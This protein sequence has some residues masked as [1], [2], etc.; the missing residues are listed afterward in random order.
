MSVEGIYWAWSHIAEIERPGWRLVLLHLA[1]RASS[2][3][4]TWA[5]VWPSVADV[6]EVTGVDRKTYRAA[7]ARFAEGLLPLVEDTGRRTGKTNQVRVYRLI[8]VPTMDEIREISRRHRGAPERGGNTEGSVF[9]PLPNLG[10]LEAP[11]Y[12]GSRRG[13]KTEGSENGPVCTTK[14]VL[15]GPERGPKTDP[16]K[17]REKTLGTNARPGAGAR[18]DAHAREGADQGQL[19]HAPSTTDA[20]PDPVDDFEGWWAHWPNKRGKDRALKAWRKR[21]RADR[22][23]AWHDLVTARRAERDPEWRRWVH[24]DDF[25]LHASTYLN[26]RRWEDQWT[27]T[28]VGHERTEARQGGGKRRD[29]GDRVQ[30]PVDEAIEYHR[31]KLEER[32]ASG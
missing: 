9:G 28:E 23:A 22:L 18:A 27:P 5:E 29:A 16:V 20:Q 25:R 14:G 6:L 32:G 10:A 24:T 8:G 11:E 19:V 30:R 2:E 12:K 21:N 1:W 13:P 7:M 4:D 3:P 31:R 26:G 17:D 15:S